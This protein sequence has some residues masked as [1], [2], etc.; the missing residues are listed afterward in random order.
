M[1]F[2]LPFALLLPLAS[3][4]STGGAAPLDPTSGSAAPAFHFAG[5][6]YFHRWSKDDQHEFTPREQTDLG[7]WSEMV[8]L[9]QYRAVNSG[10]GLAA[11]ANAVLET[12]K[13]HRAMVLKT[14]SVA[15]TATQPAEHLI[16]VLFPRPEFIEAVFARFKLHNGVG[17]AIIYSHREHGAGVGP[18]MSAWLK[19]HGLEME[20]ALMAWQQL[21][22][23][24][25]ATL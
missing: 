23:P 20:K 19:R 11:S 14:D 1:K 12:Y 17:T 16:V 8:T 6:D 9:H 15:R 4:D 25:V 24:T 21:P 13:N 10:E 22:A 5:V 3:F 7:R 2:H 18:Q